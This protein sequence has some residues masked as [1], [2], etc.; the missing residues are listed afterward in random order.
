[1]AL[2]ATPGLDS[3]APVAAY[4][5]GALPTLASNAMPLMLS[6]T[7]AF[8]NTT[9]RTP[10]PGLV[11]Y[12]LNS[13]LWTDGAI[14]TRFIALPFDGTIGSAGSPTIGF[15]PTGSW[16]FPNGT[17]IVKN[18]DLL[19]DERINPAK[20]IRRLETRLLIRNADGTL[21]GATYKWNAG[22]TDAVRV[23][24]AENETLVITQADGSTRTQNYFYPGP[25]QCLRCHNTN[26][27][28]VLGLKT[29]QL[30]GDFAYTQPNQTIRTDNQLHTFNHLGMLDTPLPD[31]TTY[32]QYVKM[33][34]VT[35]A[36]ATLEHRVRSYLASNCA[37]CHRNNFAI[38]E[39]PL[40]DASFETPILQQNIVSNSGFGAL[41]RRNL[42]ASRIYVRDASTVMP[43]PPIARNVPDQSLLA[44][45]DAFVNYAYDIATVTAPTSTQVRVQFNRAVD[46][47]SASLATNYALS[48]GATIS[49]VTLDVDPSVVLLTTSPLMAGG[50]YTV[51]VNRVK[52][53]AAPQN[54]IWPNSVAVFGAPI[55]VPGAPTIAIAQAG[56]AQATLSYSA[57]TSDGGAAISSYTAS[58]TSGPQP[59]TATTT[60]LSVTVTG[61]TNGVAYDCTVSA[62]N[63]V[64]AGPASSSVRVTPIAP[65]VPMLV[66]VV[67]QKT[68]ASAG[69]FELVID[70]APA[71][72][73]AVTVEPRGIGSGVGSGHT[74]VFRF[75][76]PITLLGTLTLAQTSQAGGAA[77]T[78]A[79]S[80][81][82]IRVT[83]AGVTDNQRVSIALA[84]ING[85][86]AATASA[87]IGFLVGDTNN[88]RSVNSSDI[89]G[90]KARSGQIT[91]SSNFRF[92]VNA[93]GSINSSDI[94][95][96]KARSGLTL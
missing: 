44:T 37:H 20:Q 38:G 14:K 15:A 66:E 55:G 2:A 69:T 78:M 93:S 62:S 90:V 39:G 32:P 9:S 21:R 81:S 28:M 75:S 56:N 40:F 85:L 6:Q 52:E 89:S 88:S 50:S 58:C 51:T 83:L 16:T 76:A 17:V 96:V 29:A 59:V 95:A 73:G 5:N 27:G 47:V 63:S 91:T 1:M 46:P 79:A 77:A 80:G 74:I 3:R 36:T 11:P 82:E 19:V 86:P 41:I 84:N 42:P 94:S 92:D 60:A 22:E 18:F 4:M 24:A 49:Q 30:N 23:D 70:R 61:L 71:I 7:G 26:A 72:N 53:A 87:S 54:P 43:M 34:A 10:H 48:S 68:H 64:G 12:A 65:P 35:D 57:P 33:A 25:D 45:Y 31:T 8:T 67:S 13:P